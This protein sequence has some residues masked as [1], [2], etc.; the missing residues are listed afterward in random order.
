[1]TQI[2]I[3]YGRYAIL[4]HILTDALLKQNLELLTYNFNEDVQYKAGHTLRTPCNSS[5]VVIS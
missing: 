4:N 3:D 2:S 1:M 5:L